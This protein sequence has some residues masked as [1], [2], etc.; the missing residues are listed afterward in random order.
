MAFFDKKKEK[1]ELHNIGAGDVVKYMTLPRILPRIAEFISTGFKTLAFFIACV[2]STVRLIPANHPYMQSK[3][4]GQFGIV[5]VLALAA[6][7]IEFRKGKADQIIVFSVIIAAIAILALQVF[8][9]LASFVMLP[10]MAQIANI[11]AP[12]PT[13]IPGGAGAAGVGADGRYDIAMILLDRVFGVPNFFNSCVSLNV[14]CTGINASGLNSATEVHTSGGSLPWPFHRGLQQMYLFYSLALLV[15]G[16][17]IFIYFIMVIIIETAQTGTPFGRRFNSV[18]APIRMVVAVGLLIPFAFGMNSAQ[19]ITLYAAKWGSGLA[20]TAW[21]NFAANLSKLSTE[22]EL[23]GTP[24]AQTANQLISFISLALA[25]EYHEETF[26]KYDPAMTNVNKDVD[27]WLVKNHSIPSQRR[28]LFTATDYASARTFYE[29][30]NVVIRFG[31]ED[32]AIIDTNLTAAYTNDT[33]QVRK[34]CGE[35]VMTTTDMASAGPQYLYDGYYELINSLWGGGPGL[36][37]TSTAPG[38]ANCNSVTNLDN[39]FNTLRTSSQAWMTARIKQNGT[40]AVGVGGAN[41]FTSGETKE[42]IHAAVKETIQ[43]L[44]NN[45][46]AEERNSGAFDIPTD[47]L[48]RGWAGAGIWYNKI[49]AMN[50]TLISAANNIPAATAY[51]L[52]MERTAKAKLRVDKNVSAGEIY[53]PKR[54]DGK[55]LNLPRGDAEVA[56]AQ[57]YYDLYKYWLTDSNRIGKASTSGNF[58]GEM[59]SGLFGLDG[60]Y[61]ITSNSGVHPLAKLVGVGKGLID[62]TIRNLTVG[63]VAMGG[64]VIATY[65]DNPALSRIGEEGGAIIGDIMFSVA[66]IGLT[67]GFVLYYVIP[68]LPFI[69]FFFAVGN[70]I[71]TVFEAMVGVPLWALAHIRIDGNGLPGD[72]AINGYYLIFEIFLRP[73]MIIFGLIAG[74]TVFAAMAAVLHDIWDIVLANVGGSGDAEKAGLIESIRGPVDKLFYLVVYTIILYMMAVSSFK[75]VELIPQ[76]I[77]RWMGANV[78]SFVDQSQDAAGGLVQYAAIGGGHMFGQITG[79]TKDAMSKGMGALKK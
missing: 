1:K 58:F 66:T 76:Q 34:A 7:N 45:A 46:V 65:I 56:A 42:N 72:A 12:Y 55:M 59:L 71:K 27:A 53:N 25:C 38:A 20:T 48:V 52:A 54:T 47:L 9:L 3:N 18:W 21:F 77:L 14:P 70:W 15:V 6:N 41:Y 50:G 5:Q 17:F 63:T 19:F 74:I 57:A 73:I 30:G 60:L 31:D 24:T 39:I 67:A 78:S 49:A 40:A 4:I 69:Y 36:L 43:C 22:Q 29:N 64:S 33:G 11:F 62:S 13:F 37:P 28:S 61:S 79:G 35:L 51:P 26:F 23:I 16:L 2:L 8:T 44:I 68:F 75:L 10:A 32:P